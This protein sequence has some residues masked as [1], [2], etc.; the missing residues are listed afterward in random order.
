MMALPSVSLSI[1]R[2]IVYQ[3]KPWTQQGPIFPVELV[4]LISTFLADSSSLRTIS[5]LNRVSKAVN[6][7]TLAVLYET[8]VYKCVPSFARTVD[9]KVLPGWKSTR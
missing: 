3:L 4:T 5:Q 8:L 6:Q 2:R 7:E 9:F 1:M